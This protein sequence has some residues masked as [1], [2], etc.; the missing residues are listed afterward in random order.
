MKT[1]ILTY[2]LFI[3]ISIKAQTPNSWA[4]VADFS[5]IPTAG[6]VSFSID[7][8]GY[9]GLGSYGTDTTV[10]DQYSIEFWQYN[11]YTD[12]WKQ[13]SNFPG[14]GRFNMI[15][16]VIGSKAYIGLGY[17]YGDYNDIWEYDPAIDTWTQKAN[18]GGGRRSD[19]SGFSIGGRGYVGMGYSDTAYYR[20]KN[21]IWEYDPNLDTWTQKSNL[22][23]LST[24]HSFLF[25]IA[26]QA[27][28]GFGANQQLTTQLNDIWRYTP[29]TD[30]WTQLATFP[31]IPISRTPFVLSIGGHG[32]IEVDYDS[33]NYYNSGKYREYFMEYDAANDTWMKKDS[34]SGGIRQGM[35]FFSIHNRGYV[36]VGSA[37]DIVHCSRAFWMYTPDSVATGI[38]TINENTI[39][40]YPNPN[41]GSFTLT[42]AGL[43][44]SSG[45][46]YTITDMLGNI[47]AQK[48]I[49]ASSQIVDLPE[50]S[51][52][53][54][55]LV[56]K[57]ASP[58]RFV[59]V[60]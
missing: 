59:V 33:A 55:T 14:G 6:G 13:K 50:A 41:K 5:G 22:P 12:T 34:F 60:R 49:T 27:Y 57:G 3:A 32:Y 23:S 7:S 54:Y 1:L 29:A 56:V 21:D 26:G 24:A 8:F 16:F 43:A 11:P 28:I 10:G 20:Y 35:A 17:Y 46:D 47:V 45:T 25:S 48:T 9:V 53:V 15:S 39:N 2:C 51:E 37:S 4:R 18:F 30:T 44:V 38:N 40:L 52:G 36:G 19:A 58:I 42:V 31:G